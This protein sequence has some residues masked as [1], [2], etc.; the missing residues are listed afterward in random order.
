LPDVSNHIENDDDIYK[1]F[2]FTQ[3]EIDLIKNGVK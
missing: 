2:N 3:E 1:I